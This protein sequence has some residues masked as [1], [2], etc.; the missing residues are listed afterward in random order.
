ME[1]EGCSVL[2]NTIIIISYIIIIL[3][4]SSLACTAR[5]FEGEKEVSNDLKTKRIGNF[6]RN[7]FIGTF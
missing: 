4:I 6:V 3:L 5:G 7:L 1:I 2:V